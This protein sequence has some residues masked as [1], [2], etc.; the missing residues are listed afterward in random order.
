M[1]TQFGVH[2]FKILTGTLE[3][4]TSQDKRGDKQHQTQPP[5]EGTEGVRS[6]EQLRFG[7]NQKQK[8]QIKTTQKQ[9]KPPGEAAA[10][11][12]PV[13]AACAVFG[14]HG[15]WVVQI[16]LIFLFLASVI[17]CGNCKAMLN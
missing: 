7:S 13:R 8:D 14:S 16:H 3:I 4:E 6:A 2:A 9:S 1:R 17:W 11:G 15:A 5:N 12:H 10:F